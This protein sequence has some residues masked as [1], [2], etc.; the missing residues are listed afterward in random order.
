MRLRKPSGRRAGR[1]FWPLFYARNGEKNGSQINHYD[2][3]GYVTPGTKQIPLFVPYVTTPTAT[4]PFMKIKS[5]A[6]FLT[7]SIYPF[8]IYA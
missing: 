2:R 1:F 3:E 4:M 7:A 6:A 8:R 5:M